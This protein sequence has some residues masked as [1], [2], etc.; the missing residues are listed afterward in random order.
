MK[1]PA[2]TRRSGSGDCDWGVWLA[3]L[4]CPDIPAN[5]RVFQS[6]I[7]LALKL[8]CDGEAGQGE[9]ARQVVHGEKCSVEIDTHTEL[10]IHM[11]RFASD[12]KPQEQMSAG[13]QR[14]PHFGER[15]LDLRTI[16]VDHRIE[17][18]NPTQAS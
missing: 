15:L 2:L 11:H 4:R 16:K 14:P 18:H 1:L 17:C 13:S 3:E 5:A 12:V 9:A 8:F 10:F 6:R 7:R